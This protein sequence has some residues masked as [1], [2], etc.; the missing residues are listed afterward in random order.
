[1]TIGANERAWL[2]TFPETAHWRK[3]L[4]V[5]G[6]YGS[7]RKYE[8]WTRSGEHLLL[9]VADE[10][11]TRRKYAEFAFIQRCQALGFPMPRPVDCGLHAGKVY[12]LLTWVEGE[13]LTQELIGMPEQ[14]Q[15]RLGQEAG[16]AL[17]AIHSVL[18]EPGE[19]READGEVEARKRM[20][21]RYLASRH[22]MAGDDA[23]VMFVAKH[24]AYPKRLAGL[25]GDFH[26]G[27][28]LLT[29]GGKL[30]VMDFDRRQVG[31]RWQDFQRAQT[32]SVP[33]STAFVNGQ[34]HAYF[35]GDPP[36]EFW[37]A[38]AYEAAYGAIRQIVW[39]ESL[40]ANA[41]EQ[42]QMSYARAA[43]DFR[44]F[45]PCEPPRWYVPAR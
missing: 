3:V 14:E 22:R 37:E 10:R 39:V 20:V 34:I 27:N 30:A 18:L 1:M 7:D 4:P 17:A 15:Y 38:F 40:G 9:R 11:E 24:V 36:Q 44:G 19:R 8:V 23:T 26:I 42:M 12:E 32:F 5:R 16:R 6:G 43:R 2:R 28:L 41:I 13:P 31:D 33:R 45:T 29:A 21:F 35:M 25:H